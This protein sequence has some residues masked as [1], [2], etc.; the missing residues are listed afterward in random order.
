ML[1]NIV[2]C[3]SYSNKLSQYLNFLR[4]I[5]MPWSGNGITIST[6]LELFKTLGMCNIYGW[7]RGGGRRERERE[8]ETETERET[9]ISRGG[10]RDR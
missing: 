7:G 10:W 4:E 9:E 1:S 5:P 8:R 2:K 3:S 6:N